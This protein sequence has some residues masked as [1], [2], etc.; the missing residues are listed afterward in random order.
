MS[1]W[2]HWTR[3]E[4][5]KPRFVSNFINEA[6][7]QRMGNPAPNMGGPAA[8]AQAM[9]LQS[10]GSGSYV[11]PK[12]G[13]VVARTVNNELIFYDNNRASGG[14]ISDSSG[15]AALTQAAPS[16]SDPMSGM[17][18][19]PPARPESPEELKAVPDATPPTA[20]KGY[21]AF[22]QQ[23]KMQMYAQPQVPQPQAPPE[24]GANIGGTNASPGEP[25]NVEAAP[26]AAFEA[27]DGSNAGMR[28]KMPGG[29]PAVGKT[30]QQMR[31][32]LQQ[33][34]GPK[35]PGEDL[36]S[37]IGDRLGRDIQDQSVISK[38]RDR[39]LKP[40]RELASQEGTDPKMM[41]RL[42]SLGSRLYK[43]EIGGRK[44]K[45]LNQMNDEIIDGVIERGGTLKDVFA[46]DEKTGLPNVQKIAQHLED[47]K[48][49]PDTP[50]EASQALWKALPPE[51][52]GNFGG[53]GK[54]PFD[55]FHD[56]VCRDGQCAMSGAWM[57][58]DFINEDH[59][60]PHSTTRSADLSDEDKDY[61]KST[62]NLWAIHKSLNQV[63]GEKDKGTVVDQITDQFGGDKRIEGLQDYLFSL[64]KERE[65][66]H[67]NLPKLL[68]STLTDSDEI[69]KFLKEDV[70]MEGI[71]GA[72]Q[73]GQHRQDVIMKDIME[74]FTSRFDP[75]GLL[76]QKPGKLSPEQKDKREKLVKSKKVIESIKSNGGITPLFRALGIP[77]TFRA[78]NQRG[79]SFTGMG[80][81]LKGV[82][83]QI[84]GQPKEKQREVIQQWSEMLSNSN[85]RAG[86]KWGEIHND[87]TLAGL[88]KPG[89]LAK[90][91]EYKKEAARH[92]AQQSMDMG[93]LDMDSLEDG[94]DKK[95]L[96]ELLSREQL[97]EQNEE[98]SF[99]FQ[100]DFDLR[101]LLKIL[102]ELTNDQESAM[103]SK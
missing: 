10:D 55:A 49:Y 83:G 86:A 90:E 85:K 82:M 25:G 64:N 48:L 75:D 44:D 36:E 95:G 79:G 39:M 57:H 59:Q 99:E 94:T 71:D 20:P 67:G 74:S 72:I 78:D 84:A 9:G 5:K 13:Q 23:R 8:R 98:S 54:K 92:V 70:D 101:D 38:K 27:F 6:D 69:G 96:L 100:D 29:L 46:L 51:M 80:S 61:I 24:I 34:M 32:D 56:W 102:M 87:D 58:P 4:Q 53:Q 28:D 21:D 17:I 65:E 41:H 7:A 31:Q 97:Y 45:K 15:G 19:V 81:I 103:I 2:A 35:T 73:M 76:G 3:G 91:L 68:E 16:W 63:M 30:F 50:I 18:T 43:D 47:T 40:L 77:T 93:Y 60:I 62:D 89:R 26:T 66:I 12:T 37:R 1:R 14:A 42:Q 88:D 33:T 11:D 22:M 52:R